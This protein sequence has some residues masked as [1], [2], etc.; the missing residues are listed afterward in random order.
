MKPKKPTEPPIT[1]RKHYNETDGNFE[2]LI[3][4]DSVDK[5]APGPGLIDIV[6]EGEEVYVQNKQIFDTAM[7]DADGNLQKIPPFSPSGLTD[8]DFKKKKKSSPRNRN[9]SSVSDRRKQDVL[10]QIKLNTSRNK[11]EGWGNVKSPRFRNKLRN[12]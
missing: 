12:T 9:K 7:L 1:G 6:T 4:L 3:S 10:A 11:E 8:F 5:M 2:E